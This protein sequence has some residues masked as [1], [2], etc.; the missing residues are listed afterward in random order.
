VSSFIGPATE[1]ALALGFLWQAKFGQFK[2]GSNSTERYLKAVFTAAAAS[3]VQSS[4]SFPQTCNRDTFL[5]FAKT[6]YDCIDA[7]DKLNAED[8]TAKLTPWRN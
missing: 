4:R 7:V 6:V 5:S 1:D 8:P 2:E 3:Y